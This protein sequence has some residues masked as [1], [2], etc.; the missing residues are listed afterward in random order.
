MH[1]EGLDS[2]GLCGA[3]Y[4][5]LAGPRIATGHWPL[6]IPIMRRGMTETILDVLYPTSVRVK[7]QSSR[8]PAKQLLA[9][10]T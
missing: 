9:P 3:K 4:L 7:D 10:L 1:D 8:V 5:T 2:I 6:A